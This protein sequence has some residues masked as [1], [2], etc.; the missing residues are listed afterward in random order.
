MSK[1]ILECPYCGSIIT[2][3]DH[4][5]PKC[6]ADCNSVIKKYHK[7]Q[8]E[9]LNKTKESI[10]KS[11]DEANKAVVMAAK[12]IIGILI[13]V[14]ISIIVLVIVFNVRHTRE[15]IIGNLNKEVTI[16]ENILKL[17]N[18]EEYEYFDD[19]FKECNTKTG[20]KKVAFKLV[21]ENNSNDTVITDEVVKSITLKAEDE[22]LNPASLKADQ[23]FCKVLVGKAEYNKFPV[24][25]VLPK[26]SITGYIGFVVPTD[27]EKLTFIINGNE[28]VK[29]HNPV[30]E[31]K[32]AKK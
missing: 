19:F 28:K 32:P 6:G 21:L 8:E 3:K 9:E 14:V 18:F 23:H 2:E 24:T 20:Y 30:Y 1:K 27:K 7:E 29:V 25:E 5:C 31:V 13:F 17:T 22:L 10:Q 12:V 15:Q 26:D 4:I 11:M 16:N